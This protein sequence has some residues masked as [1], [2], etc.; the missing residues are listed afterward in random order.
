MLPSTSTLAKFFKYRVR[1]TSQW[2]NKE[3]LAAVGIH[4][5]V[6]G[7]VKGIIVQ[8]VPEPGQRWGVVLSARGMRL[9]MLR[10]QEWGED[11]FSRRFT[12]AP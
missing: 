9:G 8:T 11:S 4:C 1:D 6:F 2:S 5:Y 7:N 3:T 10:S 12:C